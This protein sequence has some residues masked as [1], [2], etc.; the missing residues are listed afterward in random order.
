MSQA[1]AL[2]GLPPLASGGLR[3]AEPPGDHLE[4]F[5]HLA[6]QLLGM[7]RVMKEFADA[8]GK[9]I[10][11]ATSSLILS[12]LHHRFP[13]IPLDFVF[14]ATPSMEDQAAAEAAVVSRATGIATLMEPVED[15]TA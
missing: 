14:E 4:F 6:E 7:E 10:A 15:P 12:Q 2:V 5:K 9:A 8:E 1:M 13:S 11:E 3:G